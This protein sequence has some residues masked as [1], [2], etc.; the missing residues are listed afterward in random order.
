MRALGLSIA[1][2]PM[3]LGSAAR[4]ID[5]GN[6]PEFFPAITGG[7]PA[8]EFGIDDIPAQLDFEFVFE[9][10]RDPPYGGGP[11]G[12]LGRLQ[13]SGTTEAVLLVE[14]ESFWWW[15]NYSVLE[16]FY[17]VDMGGEV[18]PHF[19]PW[20]NPEPF[21]TEF[22]VTDSTGTRTY[23]EWTVDFTDEERLAVFE[24]SEGVPQVGAYEPF[25]TW[26]D[27][28]RVTA[29]AGYNFF[30]RSRVLLPLSEM[31]LE[32]VNQALM[33]D[34]MLTMVITADDELWTGEGTIAPGRPTMDLS[35]RL[36]VAAPAAIP[37][38]ATWA[39][40]GAA[41]VPLGIWWRHRGITRA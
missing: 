30:G 14:A 1:L 2:V 18:A 13:Q 39:L 3:L 15:W 31:G 8:D 4:G 27:F 16:D 24:D 36:I 22:T 17:D 11:H 19:Q 35:V 20:E 12:S 34:G 29:G 9:D 6:D 32:D 5:L 40:L 37:E 25:E 10:R 41:G 7:N 33:T 38:P 26:T 28:E 23:A 21:E